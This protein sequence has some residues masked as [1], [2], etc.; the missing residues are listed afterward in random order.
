MSA[1]DCYQLV[2]LYADWLKE[3]VKLNTIGDVC[4]LTTPFIDRHNDY[5]QIYVK[6]IPSGILLTDDGYTI[7]DLDLLSSKE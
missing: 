6:S 7:K 1:L 2:N 4:E 5:L 3:R